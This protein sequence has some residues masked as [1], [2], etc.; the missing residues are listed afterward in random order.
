MRKKCLTVLALSIVLLTAT[1]SPAQEMSVSQRETFWRGLKLPGSPFVR[2]TDFKRRVFMRVP[3][4]WKEQGESVFIGPHSSTLNI[5]LEEIPD[6]LAFKDYLAALMQPI[7]LGSYLAFDF[8]EE[9][10]LQSLSAHPRFK[11]LLDD[12]NKAQEDQ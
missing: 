7:E 12:F 10:D 9:E 5:S 1:S 3:A 8:E 6:G 2:R 11:K 4:D